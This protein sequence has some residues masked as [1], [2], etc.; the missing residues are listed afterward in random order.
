MRGWLGSVSPE[1]PAGPGDDCA[2][3]RPARGLELLT[4][5]PVVHGVH[6]DGRVS[7][8]QAGAKLLKRNLSDIAAMGGRP[9]AALVALALEGRVSVAWLAGFYRG[10]GAEAR[11]HG[12]KVVGGDVTTLPAGFAATLTLTGEA[13]GRVLT[14]RGTRKGDWIYVTGLLGRSLASGHHFLFEPRLAEGAWLA[15]RAEVRAMMDLSDGIAKDIRELAPRGAEPALY[16]DMLPRRGAA[17]VREALS[18]GEDYELLFTV[19]AGRGP[20]LLEAA[21]GRAFPATRLTRIGRFV[22]RGQRPP[23]AVDLRAI[24]GFQHLR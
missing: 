21:W 16:A 3:V 8:R 17:S 24:D 10:L 7:A 18:D 5:D 22:R 15:R 4:V 9:R 23:D 20:R 14:R 1:T 6:F 11:R 2:V 12:V 19:A 13:P